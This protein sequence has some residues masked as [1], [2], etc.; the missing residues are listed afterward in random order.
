MNAVILKT[1]KARNLGFGMK[2]LAKFLAQRKFVLA[3]CHAHSNAHNP[4]K[5]V[6]LMKIL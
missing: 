5:T 6:A 4:H 3:G 2:K 1:I